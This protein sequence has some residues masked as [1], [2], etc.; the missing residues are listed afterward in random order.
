MTTLASIANDF[1]NALLHWD[2]ISTSVN[3]R[4]HH[5]IQQKSHLK[6]KVLKEFLLVMF[7]MNLFWAETLKHINLFIASSFHKLKNLS[8]KLKRYH[9]SKKFTKG[10]YLMRKK[11]P[12]FHQKQISRGRG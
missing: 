5:F 1:N 2:W 6:E 7:E 10:R 9:K 3:R 12:D 11:L 8:K 4:C